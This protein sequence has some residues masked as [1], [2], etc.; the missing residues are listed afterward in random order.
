MVRKSFDVIGSEDAKF[1][2][3]DLRFDAGMD[4]ADAF[5]ISSLPVRV[6]ISVPEDFF[7]P[8]SFYVGKGTHLIA[9]EPKKSRDFLFEVK[10]YARNHAVGTITKDDYNILLP[11]A[12]ITSPTSSTQIPM[13]VFVIPPG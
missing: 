10:E 6:L 5:I 13:R 12:Y 1:E 2:S 8:S 3:S 11:V 4:P 9:G 7:P